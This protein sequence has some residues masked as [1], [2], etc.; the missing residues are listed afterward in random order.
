MLTVAR[1]IEMLEAE[2]AEDGFLGRL[3]R[4]TFEPSGYTR[5][6]E[7]LDLI[8]FKEGDAIDRRLVSLLWFVPTLMSYQ[9]E[10]VAERGGDVAALDQ[11]LNEVRSKLLRDIL[12]TP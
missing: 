2:W 3:R 9:R 4:G 6:K 1:L 11:A 12:G 5:L 10:R 7:K 8:R